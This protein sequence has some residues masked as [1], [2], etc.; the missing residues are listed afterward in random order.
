MKVVIAGAGTQGLQIARELVSENRDVV[1]IEQNPDVAK[2]IANELDCL[3]KE[4]NCE[5]LDD[6]SEAGL[7][8]ADWFI[9]LSGSDNANI[10]ACGLVAETF[11]RPKTIARVRSPYF[12]S[13]H[14]RKR[15]IL[16]VDYILNPEAETAQVVARLVFRGMSSEI[17]DVKEAGIQLRKLIASDDPRLPGQNLSEVRSVVGKNFIIPAVLREGGELYIPSGQYTFE[18]NDVV[19]LLG[20]PG[21]LDRLF[22]HGTHLISKLKRLVLIGA[23]ALSRQVLRELGVPASEKGSA[24]RKVREKGPNALS[25]LGNPSIKV[26]EENKEAAKQISNEFPDVD[27]V[28]RDLSDEFLIEEEGVGRADIILCLT[29]SQSA[30]LVTALIAKDSGATR[31]LAVVYNDL[32]MRLENLVDID[33]MVNQKSVVEGA[34]LDIVRKANIRRLHSFAEGSFELVELSIEN[35]YL[36]A[37]SRIADLGLPRGILV[38][39]VIHEGQTIIPT[40]D[41][42]IQVRDIVGLVLPKEQISRL[43]TLF[44]A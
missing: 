33:A 39:F 41:T 1:I 44:G 11:S 31:S 15:R 18:A 35:D 23:G 24:P 42:K 2:S 26:I 20:E 37:G 12:S 13:F 7:E 30:N 36:K 4:G 43:E 14:S 3:V 9:A 40:G 32:Y 17:V 16:G 34:I 28:C 22:G 6:L 38:A 21:E 29:E 27:V 25:L 19:F 5:N 10:V 8:D